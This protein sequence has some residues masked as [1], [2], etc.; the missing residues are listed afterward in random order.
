MLLHLLATRWRMFAN[1][2]RTDPRGWQRV[3]VALGLGLL[4]MA[5]IGGSV[6]WFFGRCL[7]IEP[8]GE[9]VIRRMLGIVLLTIF[10]LLSFSNLVGAFSSLYLADDLQLLM[11]RPVPPYP[12]FTARFAE[13]SLHASWMIVPFSLPIFLD[14][15]LHFAAGAGYYLALAGVY[16]GLVIIPTSLGVLVSLLLASALSARRARH[17]MVFVG[18]LTLGLLMFLLRAMQPE[19]FMNPDS[20]APLLEALQAL[21]GTDPAWLPSTWACD[22]LWLHL[23]FGTTP[24]THPVLLLLS[25]SAMSFFV[26]AWVFRA[27]HWHAY[28]RAQDG[29][30]DQGSAL[31]PRSP[32]RIA[33]ILAAA[34]SRLRRRKL[35]L[36]AGLR[37]KDRLV[38]VRDTAQWSQLLVLVAIVGIYILNFKY[39]RVISGGG[40][41][42]DL[43]LHFMNLGLS[44]FV[45]MALIA[46]FVFPAVS[47]EGRA[48][49]LIRTSPN[50][51]RSFL[52]AKARN[53]AIL[54]VIFGNLLMILTHLFLETD[55]LLV[56]A[57]LVTITPLIDGLV[58]LGL[59]LGAC[60]PRFDTDNAAKIA[61]GLGGVVF[62]LGGA[63]ILVAVV[64]AA[65]FPTVLLTRALRLGLAPGTFQLVGAGFSALLAFAIPQG[66]GRLAIRIGA[67]HLEESD[68]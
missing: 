54:L 3:A 6:H 10:G 5:A 44:G 46:R 48:F 27:L 30:Q 29:L 15:G 45:V 34:L 18:T 25:T 11:S 68:R 50:T 42:T 49:W 41:L 38:F 56:V 17:I 40:L 32:I 61:T 7:E 31:R 24:G 43:G 9:L 51:M 67:R 64:L 2:W 14:A 20:R 60:Y 21:Q 37:R 62:M 8:V 19:Q 16:I 47:L 12:L 23:G 53:L 58:G 35:S 28:S 55:P 13:T 26:C 22:A 59:G 1:T 63:A 66:V 52:N 65:I 39:I 33:T 4:L 57:S 36:E